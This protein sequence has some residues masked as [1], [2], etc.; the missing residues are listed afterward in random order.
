MQSEGKFL[1]QILQG[2]FFFLE[3]CIYK[4][5]LKIFGRHF[6]GE[7]IMEI[8]DFLTHFRKVK[9]NLSPSKQNSVGME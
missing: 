5:L 3:V 9:K 2:F 4:I 1:D 6:Q 8:F 7:W